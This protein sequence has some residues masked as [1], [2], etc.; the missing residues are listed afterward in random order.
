MSL[1][2]SQFRPMLIA[3]AVL[4]LITFILLKTLV[5]VHLRIDSFLAGVPC[6]LL[7]AP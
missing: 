2:H 5:A 7:E 3:K 4:V 6:E 1:P